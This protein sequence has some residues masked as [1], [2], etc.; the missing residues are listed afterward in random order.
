[1]TDAEIIAA[2]IT[3]VED[4]CSGQIKPDI[5]SWQYGV[6]LILQDDDAEAAQTAIDDAYQ[7]Q[8]LNTLEQIL[9]DNDYTVYKPGQAPP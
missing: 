4:C 7:Q 6:M 8:H 1:M 2:A 5:N 3:Y 9:T